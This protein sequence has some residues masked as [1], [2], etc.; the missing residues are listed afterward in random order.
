MTKKDRKKQKKAIKKIATKNISELFCFATKI[1]NES[2]ELANR[3][4]KIAL[5]TR[6]K[7]NIKLTKKQKSY[8]CKKCHTFLMPGENCTVRT[9]N[10]NI[11][12][13]CDN[14]GAIRKFGLKKDHK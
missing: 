1:F 7:S 6:N 4:V 9:K 14:C 2:R 8:Y 5:L 3:Y 13:H 10:K 12:Y 11:L